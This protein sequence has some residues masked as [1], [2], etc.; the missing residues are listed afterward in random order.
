MFPRRSPPFIAQSLKWRIVVLVITTEDD[1]ELETRPCKPDLD[2]PK[3]PPPNAH[4]FWSAWGPWGDCEGFEGKCGGWG[5]RE[6]AKVCLSTRPNTK[7]GRR[8]PGKPTMSEKCEG[9][10]YKGGFL[11]FSLIDTSYAIQKS[12]GACHCHCHPVCHII[13]LTN[14]L[15]IYPQENMAGP[16]GK[17]GRPAPRPVARARRAAAERATTTR[18]RTSQRSSRRA[19]AFSGRRRPATT[20]SATRSTTTVPR[21]RTP[22]VCPRRK[23]TSEPEKGSI[24]QIRYQSIYLQCRTDNMWIIG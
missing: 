2:V 22:R 7:E 6:R 19:R 21:A 20:A 8:C 13:P 18:G 16:S 24:S 4:Y 12:L 15:L 10:C 9:L 5:T 11:S 1:S 3:C 14:S 23:C 17:C